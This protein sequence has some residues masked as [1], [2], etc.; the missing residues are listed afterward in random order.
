MKRRRFLQ[1]TAAA[2]A[3]PNMARAETVWHGVA[4]GADATLRLMGPSERAQAALIG[5]AS[6]LEKVEA[7]F[8][9][10]RP[11][12]LTALNAQ[13]R[14]TPSSWLRQVVDLADRLHGLTEGAF[15][16]SVQPLWRALAEGRDPEA[17]RAHVGWDRVQLAPDII[18]NQGQALTFN[19]I[20]QGFATDLVRDH[21]ARQGFDHALINIGE[22]AALGGPFHLGV[23]DPLAGLLAE[24]TVRSGALAVSS[25]F[26]TALAGQAHIL[27]PKGLS[28]L[29]STVA[30]EADTAALADGLSTA[31]VFS[32]AAQVATLKAALPQVRR[33]ALVDAAGN[34]ETV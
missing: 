23:A 7:T 24:W 16:P 28:P 26:G 17:A 19:G 32:T 12:E 6:V 27:H 5:L 13:G 9:L 34:L 15:D 1:V 14:A 10:Y 8:S 33:V 18:L 31:L 29:W 2:L 25:P 20:A 4:L 11:S 3:M 22:Y 30:V 21:L